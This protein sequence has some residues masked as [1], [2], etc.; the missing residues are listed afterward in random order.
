MCVRNAAARKRSAR[1]SPQSRTKQPKG[2]RTLAAATW[3]I[4]ESQ[5][6]PPSVDGLIAESFE[7]EVL[8]FEG[9]AIQASD[10]PEAARAPS[11][12]RHSR[13]EAWRSV[14]ECG[15]KRGDEERLMALHSTF[16]GRAV[17]VF[18]VRCP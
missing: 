10:N 9:E 4:L 2:G 7:P 13:K 11:V 3:A 6:V 8:V 18:L 12:V 14:I 5:P 17:D 15:V 1:P 16:F